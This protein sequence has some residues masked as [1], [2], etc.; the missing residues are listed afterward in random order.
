MATTRSAPGQDR[1][2]W[3]SH[4]SSFDRFGAR[5]TASSADRDLRSRRCTAVPAD[6]EGSWISGGKRTATRVH[7]AGPILRAR[8]C[9]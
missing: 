8:W 9:E 5:T 4:S 7:V 3:R 1:Q 2:L 6:G